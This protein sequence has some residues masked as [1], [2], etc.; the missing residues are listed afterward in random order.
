MNE[1]RYNGFTPSPRLCSRRLLL[2]ARIFA[3]IL[4]ASLCIPVTMAQPNTAAIRFDAATRVFRIDA[5]DTSYILGI[6]EQQQVQ[7]LYWG[8]RLL[9][10]DTFAA[11]RAMP[12]VAS[13]DLPVTTTPHEFVGW[14][15]G[16]FVEPDLKIT[17]PD[18]N[19]DLVL[20]YVTH[21][22]DGNKLSITLKDVS[23]EVYVTLQYQADSGG[24]ILRRSAEIENRTNAP[25]TIEQV[26][27]A[28]WNLPR[29]MDYR[30][31]YLTGR[32]A[33]EWNVQEERIHPGKKCSRVAAALPA[34]RI[35]L[36]MPSTTRAV[37]IRRPVMFGL[38]PLVG[39]GPGKSPSNRTNCSKFAL[40]AGLMSSISVTVSKK[41]ND[42]RLH[43]LRWILQ[44]GHRRRIATPAPF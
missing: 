38:A 40:Q 8:K 13:F 11:V 2:Q 30:L 24:G 32:W 12:A 26:G 22:I 20:K 6:N 19:R 18:G 3:L 41:A 33:A 5:G 34:I 17:F 36:G 37:T 29:G 16:L 28:T 1:A 42:S 39:A 21:Q 14:G 25:F 10:S 23:R 4:G 44:P 15:G 27:A 43:T 7:T 35:I 31:R 9:A